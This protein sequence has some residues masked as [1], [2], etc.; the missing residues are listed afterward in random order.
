MP[1]RQKVRGASLRILGRSYGPKIVGLHNRFRVR[2]DRLIRY[3]D[4]SRDERL[5]GIPYHGAFVPGRDR[6]RIYLRPGADEMTLVHELMHG[7]LYT[8]GFA[9]LRASGEDLARYPA[10]GVLAGRV[11]DL[12]VH[13]VLLQRLRRARFPVSREELL[14]GARSVLQLGSVE[15]APME[16]GRE[17]RVLRL[18]ARAVLLAEALLRH[19]EFREPL[20]WLVAETEPECLDLSE[21]LAS[22]ARWDSRRN[23]LRHRVEIGRLLAFLDQEALRRG[24]DLALRD[25]VLLP[26][27]LTAGRLDQPARRF[28]SVEVRSPFPLQERRSGLTLR[29][30]LDGTASAFRLYGSSAAAARVRAHLEGELARMTVSEFLSRNRIDVVAMERQGRARILVFDPPAP[31][32]E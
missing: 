3:L 14:R 18:F 13:P 12:L 2:T 21:Q 17:S 20:R 1:I 23:S 29:F 7:I 4:L 22:R 30:R 9:G 28:F 31:S 10:L 16:E 5:A 26:P 6:H 19:P 8:E 15:P 32:G 24:V 11:G 27:F 25:R